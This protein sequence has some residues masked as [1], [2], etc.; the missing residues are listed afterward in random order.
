MTRRQAPTT[1]M[2][3]PAILPAFDGPPTELSSATEA[4]DDGPAKPF[5][6]VGPCVMLRGRVDLVRVGLAGSSELI[7]VDGLPVEVDE[8]VDEVESKSVLD[9]VEELVLEVSESESGAD[10][11]DGLSGS[12]VDES[13]ESDDEDVEDER[14]SEEG[15]ETIVVTTLTVDTSTLSLCQ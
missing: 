1:P 6:L 10:D 7:E 13:S 2:T 11:A 8:L 15:T 9:D 4:V 3:M 5:V 12:E 14:L